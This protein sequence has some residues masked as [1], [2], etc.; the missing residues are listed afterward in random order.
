MIKKLLDN[1]TM[2]IMGIFT[3]NLNYIPAKLKKYFLRFFWC[4]VNLVNPFGEIGCT[5]H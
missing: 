4:G 2:Q 1:K 5:E 3:K